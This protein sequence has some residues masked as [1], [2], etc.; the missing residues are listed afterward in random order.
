MTFRPFMSLL[1][2]L[3]WV[4]SDARSLQID[5]AG[6]LAEVSEH[7]PRPRR[8]ALV[9]SEQSLSDVTHTGEEQAAAEDS[10][11]AQQQ[12][13]AAQEEA[14]AAAEEAN[15]E[16]RFRENLQ[17]DE[18]ADKKKKRKKA[19]A[20]KC[21]GTLIAKCPQDGADP[22]KTK[23]AGNCVSVFHSCKD[24]VLKQ[25]GVD[26]HG[27]CAS[28]GTTCYLEC[29]GQELFGEKC[30]SQPEGKCNGGFVSD[31]MSGMSCMVSPMDA[32][33]CIDAGTCALPQE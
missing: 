15:A 16:Y 29:S 8:S 24:D 4:A 25:C 21:V 3:A 30:E 26:K 20:N 17:S 13:D 19:R 9:R 7:Q 28:G 33:Q 10:S 23:D 5:S 12:V 6:S 31:G 1:L 2:A 22:C 18:L 32:T 11:E 14:S 27:K